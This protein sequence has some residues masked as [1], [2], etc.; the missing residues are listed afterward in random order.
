MAG[1]ST[2]VRA[3]LILNAGITL[4]ISASMAVGSIEETI[5]VTGATPVVDVQNVRGQTTLTSEILRSVP[6]STNIQGLARLTLGVTQE[7]VLG[8]GDSGGSKGE[9]VYGFNQVHGSPT[10]ITMIDGMKT[11]SAYRVPTA[12]RCLFNNLTAR[13]IIVE[14][15]GGDPES[16]SAGVNIN[17]IPREGGNS[18]SGSVV[19]E[20]TNSSL[21]AENNLNDS[22]RDRFV[23][24]SNVTEHIYDAGVGIGGPIVADKLWFY[25]AYRDWGAKESLAGNFRN[26]IPE[27]LFYEADTDRPAQYDR[28][29]RDASLRLTWQATDKQKLSLSSGVQ[30]Y[31]WIGA[32]FSFGPPEGH[33]DFLVFPNNNHL[34]K[35]TYAQ[36]NSIL[37]EAALSLRTDR[38]KNGLPF[39]DSPGE[40]RSVNDRAIGVYGSKCC[41]PTGDTDYGDVG[42]QYAYQ[43]KASMSYI[44]GA[45][46]VKVGFQNMV[47]QHEA[48]HIQGVFD[49]QYL[50]DNR[51]PTGIL[52]AAYPHA[53]LSKLKYNLGIFA[54]D[55]WTVDRL[56]LNLGVRLDFLNGYN[57]AQT[58][59]GGQ[60]TPAIS[61]PEADWRA[62]LEGH[63]PASGSRLRPLW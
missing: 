32:Y 19:G 41:A 61:F 13:E 3:E 43:M 5:T 46:V 21:Q 37:Y 44:T 63:L 1:F 24:Q 26:K 58:R 25:G 40:R 14:T 48:R 35:W 10:G 22:L 57:P 52:Q 45:H 36:S 42:N 55:T 56:T 38:Q 2:V 7:G 20:F 51:V 28:Y 27:T 8:G 17:L 9:P 15:S 30:T 11:S 29:Q 39:P 53:Q 31:N 23:T 4:A 33:W 62:Q 47:G 50:F 16:E 18:F 60:Y 12:H 59:P 54:Q 34:V 6:T 49:E